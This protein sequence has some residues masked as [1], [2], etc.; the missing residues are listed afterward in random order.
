MPKRVLDFDA[1]WGSDK[2]AA[3]SSWAQAEYAWLYGLADASGCFELTNL[4]VIWGRVAAIRRDLTIERLEQVFT[5]FQEQGLLFVWEHQ[6]KRYAHWT[7]SDVPGRLPP[8]SWRMRLERFAPPVPKQRLAEYM[9]RFA[10]GRAALAGAGFLGEE[11]PEPAN[12]KGDCKIENSELE[13]GRRSAGAPQSL[14][15]ADPRLLISDYGDE[16]GTQNLELKGNG[17][18]EG[19]AA[20]SRNE[21]LE[22]SAAECDGRDRMADD[23]A[24]ATGARGLKARVEEGQAQDL[25]LDWNLNGKRDLSVNRGLGGRGC[26]KSHARSVTREKEFFK[27]AFDDSSSNSKTNQ[28]L[29]AREGPEFKSCS[30]ICQSMEQPSPAKPSAYA[31]LRAKA[32]DPAMKV[33]LSGMGDGASEQRASDDFTRK[34]GSYAWREKEL[35]VERELRVG[36][37]PVCGPVGVKPE[38]LERIRRR[39]AARAAG[40]RS[41]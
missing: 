29:N 25:G 24:A 36:L 30:R 32:P 35:A 26:D 14:Q 18:A 13:E 39:E 22:A 17:E 41:P 38:V 1:L 15:I 20:E 3:C 28:G 9:S 33:A 10:R 31:N 40:S 5:E 12:R 7:G 21:N 8:P 16:G 34:G 11:H 6:G 2:L 37:G 4:R 23:L 19:K 27:T